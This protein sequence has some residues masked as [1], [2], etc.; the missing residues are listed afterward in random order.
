MKRVLACGVLL[1][2]FGH[3][4]SAS[5]ACPKVDDPIVRTAEAALWESHEVLYG[6]HASRGRAFDIDNLFE[7]SAEPARLA[8]RYSAFAYSATDKYD[9]WTSLIEV[10]LWDLISARFIRAP[11]FDD[12][13]DGGAR[14]I[15]LELRA[16]GSMGVLLG[17]GDFGSREIWI[18]PRRGPRRMI[19][20][21]SAI[22]ATSFRRVGPY[23][24]WKTAGTT[25]QRRLP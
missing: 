1:L 6:C 4:A 2:A 17:S 16:T 18:V 22:D 23:L 21:S 7:A 5:A 10:Q 13:F 9:G 19:E 15:D 8:G 24:T 11:R 14:V 3:A 25:K 12:R 20:R